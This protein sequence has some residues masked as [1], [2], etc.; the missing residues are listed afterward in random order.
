[1]NSCQIKSLTKAGHAFKKTNYVPLSGR[2]ATLGTMM[3]RQS[4][5]VGQSF[6]ET[7][8]DPKDFCDYCCAMNRKCL[9]PISIDWVNGLSDNSK[10]LI[11]K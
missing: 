9:I 7:L 6:R 8:K 5:T 4:E 10:Y 3:V 2:P 1:M 11:F